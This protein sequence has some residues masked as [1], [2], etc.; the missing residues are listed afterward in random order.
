MKSGNWGMEIHR[1]PRDW[2]PR[3]GKEGKESIKC[4]EPWRST[5]CYFSQ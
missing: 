2:F 1:Q 4:K 3:M 5:E